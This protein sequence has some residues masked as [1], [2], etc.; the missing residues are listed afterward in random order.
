[1]AGK[2]KRQRG[3]EKQ[4][5]AAAKKRIKKTAGS[6]SQNLKDSRT[7]AVEPGSGAESSSLDPKR[8]AISVPEQY[9][10]PT[11]SGQLSGD[12]QGLPQENLDDSESVEELV[13]EGQDLEAELVQGVESAP[14]G[15]Q[16]GVRTHA[17]PEPEDRTPDYK[18][19]NR[20]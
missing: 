17:P 5:H 16:G 14:P 9:S 2:N 4:K 10:T 20:L 1:M 13:E 8:N 15:D 6:N 3:S 18:N 11:K 7:S 19:R 12:T